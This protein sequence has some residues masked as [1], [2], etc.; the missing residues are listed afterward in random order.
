MVDA[1]GVEQVQTERTQLGDVSFRVRNSATNDADWRRNTIG[2]GGV[3]AAGWCLRDMKLS[4]GIVMD[5]SEG[6]LRGFA[7]FAFGSRDFTRKIELNSDRETENETVDKNSCGW[8]AGTDGGVRHGTGTVHHDWHRWPDGRVFCRGAVDLP[9]RESRQRDQQ[10]E[11]HSTLDRRL[12]REHQ[13]DCGRRH[14]S[15]RCPVRLAIP[16]L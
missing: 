10:P 14:G 5:T 13:R 4:P 1:L 8:R 3:Q 12:D 16:R 2:S 7:G 6:Q 15:R 11:V 9:P